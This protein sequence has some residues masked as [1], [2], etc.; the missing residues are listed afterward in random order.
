VAAFDL[1]TGRPLWR[2]DV[3]GG[4]VSSVALS[5]GAAVATATDGKVRAYELGDGA[6]RWVYEAGTP[7]FAPPAVSKGVVYAGDLRGVI[8]AIDLGSG[9]G[10]W[11]LDLATEPQVMA[12]GMIYGGPVVQDGRLYVAT[13]NLAGANAGRPTAV[14]CIGER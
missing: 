12:P 7:F 10:K 6:P 5:D 13:C 1:D 2:K 4:V 9:A 8:H 14:V 11:K 3:K